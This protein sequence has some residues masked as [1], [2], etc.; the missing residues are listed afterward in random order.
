VGPGDPTIPAGTPPVYAPPPDQRFDRQAA[1]PPYPPGHDPYA[2]QRGHDYAAEAAEFSRRHIRTPETKEFFKT[3]EFF[4]WGLT[5][6]AIL[7]A[8]A[9]SD[10]FDGSRIWITAAV[11]SAAYILSRGIAK[12]GARR[13]DPESHWGHDHR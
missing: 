2:Q 9:A 4:V 8:G 11:V 6:L 7:I 5:F 3:S 12:A 13:G 10:T 1:P